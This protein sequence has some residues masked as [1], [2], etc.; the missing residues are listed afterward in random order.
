MVKKKTHFEDRAC[1]MRCCVSTIG[2]EKWPFSLSQQL[3][4]SVIARATGP[5]N[6]C[7]ILGHHVLPPSIEKITEHAQQI[8]RPSTAYNTHDR[9]NNREEYD[10]KCV[11]S[12]EFSIPCDPSNHTE[13]RAHGKEREWYKWKNQISNTPTW[14]KR[15]EWHRKHVHGITD[16]EDNY[17]PTKRHYPTQAV[18]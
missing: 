16:G 8:Y 7:A 13:D 12:G 1:R 11:V 15:T 18:S 4:P 5:K 14:H 17:S 3:V 2:I 6:T 10:C 9:A